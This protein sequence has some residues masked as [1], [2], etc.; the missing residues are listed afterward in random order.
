VTDE[1]TSRRHWWLGWLALSAPALLQLVLLFSAVL[2]RL[3]YPYDLEWME[4]GLLNH[5]ARIADGAGIYVQ[6]S[7]DFIPFLYTPLYPGLLA[8]LEPVTGI[9]YTVGRTIS[10]L[11]ILAIIGFVFLAL[12]PRVDRRERPAAAAGGV[13]AIGYFAATYPWVDGWY[14]LVRGDTLFLAMVIGGL[15]ALHAWA[16]ADEGW[17]GQ[18]RIAGAAAILG[19]SFFCKQTGVLF[20]AA[21]GAMVLVLS[22]RRLPIYVAVTGAI[23]LGGT[24]LLNRMTG[25]WFWTYAFEVHQTHDCHPGRFKDGFTQILGKFPLMTGTI[26]LGLIAVAAVA[27]GRRRLVRSSAPLLVWTWCFLVALVVGAVG[28]ATQWSHRN[29]YIPAMLTGAMAAGA[30]IPAICASVDAF[31]GDGPRRRLIGPIVGMVIL[32]ALVFDLALLERW[33]PGNY[34]PT[35]RDRA[36]GDALIEEIRSIDGEVFIPFHPWYARLAGKRVY[37]HRMGVLDMRYRPPAHRTLPQCFFHDSTGRSNWK[38]VGLPDAFENGYFAAVIWDNRHKSFFDGFERYYRLD[39]N[40]PGRM[41]PRLFSGA[42]ELRPT[43]IWVPAVSKPPPAGATALFDFESGRYGTDWEPVGRAWG[44]RPERAALRA[45]KQGT[46][47]RYGGRF[48]ATSMHGGDDALG[49]LTSREVELTGPRITLKLSGGVEAAELADRKRDPAAADDATPWLRVELHAAGEIVRWA[50][51][52]EPPSE[53][54]ETVTWVVPELV[55]QKVRFV[56]VDNRKGSWAHLNVDDIW[57]WAE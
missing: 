28:I 54:M 31:A 32:F 46:V 23:G 26:V 25:G 22:W 3:T 8:L 5:A 53:R 49:T 2:R 43:E 52:A 18:A 38:V 29:A 1:P 19:L 12:V 42:S 44:K 14:D 6:P 13:V 15:V 21:G 24:W 34:V 9:S 4:G 56:L 27:I 50:G 37:T 36:A 7:L 10:L 39:D 33:S 11:S 17:R 41:R 40:L 30:A 55:G 51:K 16:R 35:D 57:V 47:R 45:F 48:Y 20:V